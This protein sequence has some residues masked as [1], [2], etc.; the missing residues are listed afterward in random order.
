MDEMDEI[1]E[2]VPQGPPFYD[3]YVLLFGGTRN[4]I[5]DIVRGRPANR[6]GYLLS[7]PKYQAFIPLS[8]IDWDQLDRKLERIIGDRHIESVVLKVPPDPRA[9]RPCP[10]KR[11]ALEPDECL[12][13]ALVT[14]N[15]LESGSIDKALRDI[16]ALDVG[17]GAQVDG[18]VSILVEV[19]AVAEQLKEALE[20]I[21]QVD[22]ISP[23]FLYG[24]PIDSTDPRCPG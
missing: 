13:F 11:T 14:V 12:A 19:Q 18:P 16:G 4:D 21:R 7:D 10:I 22:N 3:A 23:Y 1:D 2:A 9:I 24:S 17:P 15:S 5:E 20:K 8:A 6:P